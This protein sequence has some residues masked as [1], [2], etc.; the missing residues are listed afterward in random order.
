MCWSEQRLGIQ[1]QELFQVEVWQ[2]S[3]DVEQK[4]INADQGLEEGKNLG[5]PS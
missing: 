1:G 2:A 3:G 4:V 5:L